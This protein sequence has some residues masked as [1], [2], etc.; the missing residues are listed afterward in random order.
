MPLSRKENRLKVIRHN[1]PYEPGEEFTLHFLT[2]LHVGSAFCDESLL[3]S[4]VNKIVKNPKALWIGGGDY[5]DFINR[6]DKRHRES[7]IAPWIHGVD[8]VVGIQEKYILD[9]LSPIKD[10]CLGL[11][12]GN[13]EDDILDRYERDVYGSLVN[14]FTA[15]SRKVRLG[16]GGFVVVCWQTLNKTRWTTT[17]FVHHGSGGGLLPGGH[18]LTLGRLPTWYDFDVALLGHRHV[19]QWVPNL[20][21]MPNVRATGL[22]KREQHMLFGGTYL[23]TA[24]EGEP[25]SERKL[26]PPK[27]VGGIQIKFYPSSKEI[28]CIV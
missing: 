23:D 20:I 21:T 17:I 9:K 6:S 16:V 14:A 2:D 4:D 11:A 24:V 5:G 19:K 13:H 1:V 3:D 25:Y 10:K 7:E 12:K 28:R 22:D 26:L 8:D 18:A 27:G 15:E